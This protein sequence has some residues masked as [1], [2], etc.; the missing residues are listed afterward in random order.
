MG[1]GQFCTRPGPGRSCRR[2]TRARRSS[3]SCRGCSRRATPGTLL[4]AVG[5]D[6]DRGG[7]EGADRQRRARAGR[8][9]RRST[10]IAARSS[11]RCCEVSAEQ[12]LATPHALQTEAFGTVNTVVVADDVAQMT[13][14]AARAGGQPHRLRLQRHH[15]QGRRRLRAP[16]AP[17]C[18]ARSAGCSTTRCRPASRCRPR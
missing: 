17:C 6:G 18:A 15:R 2:A 5:R 10:A 8:R 13:E 12:F 1:A 4:G 11:R 9:P 14:V 7:A 3:P 16:G